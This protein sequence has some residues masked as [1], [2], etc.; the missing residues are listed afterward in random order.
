MSENKFNIFNHLQKTKGNSIPNRIKELRLLVKEL[1]KENNELVEKIW[2][3]NLKLD[4]FRNEEETRE[5][6]NKKSNL[7]QQLD[8]EDYA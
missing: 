5:L 3:I 7:E 6:L 2:D 1:N 8:N 4:E